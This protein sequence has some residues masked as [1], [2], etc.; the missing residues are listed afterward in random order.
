M[1]T[2]VCLGVSTLL[3]VVALYVKVDI[4]NKNRSVNEWTLKYS[5]WIYLTIGFVFTL[6]TVWVIHDC[7]YLNRSILDTKIDQSFL[8]EIT[9]FMRKDFHRDGV[10]YGTQYLLLAISFSVVLY[11]FFKMIDAPSLKNFNELKE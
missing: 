3:M 9:K 8:Q 4:I 5:K 7:V 11:M 2:K 6:N 1:A 10:F